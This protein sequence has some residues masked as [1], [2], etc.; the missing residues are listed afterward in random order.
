M[1]L[2]DLLITPISKALT[3]GGQR[4]LGAARRAVQNENS[5]ALADPRLASWTL[6]LTVPPVGSV[7]CTSIPPVGLGRSPHQARWFRSN[8]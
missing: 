6:N 3:W 7:A 8:E 1:I 2:E 5:R 4:L